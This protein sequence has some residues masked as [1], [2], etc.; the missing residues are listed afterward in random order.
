MVPAESPPRSGIQAG[1]PNMPAH[2]YAVAGGLLAGSD[3]HGMWYVYVLYDTH[4]DRFY[5]GMTRDLR[6]RLHEHAGGATHTTARMSDLILL[7]YEACTSK[8]DA[9]ARERQ[10]KTGFGRGYLRRRLHNALG[11]RGSMAER[12]HDTEKVEG[13]IPSARIDM[14]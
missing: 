13:S 4:R 6:R 5:I 10:L 12:L 3:R 1:P 2:S 9:G 8:E 14:T 7:Y 11:A